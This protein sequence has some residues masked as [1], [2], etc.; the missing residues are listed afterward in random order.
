MELFFRRSFGEIVNKFGDV[1]QLAFIEFFQ[2]ID[3]LVELLRMDGKKD[4]ASMKA[5]KMIDNRQ[6][7]NVADELKSSMRK[8]IAF[9]AADG[10]EAFVEGV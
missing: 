4:E 2:I 1:L 9:K 3:Q 8:D 6:M 7:G 5:P 10:Y